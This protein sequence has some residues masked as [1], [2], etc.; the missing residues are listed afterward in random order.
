M[1]YYDIPY[2]EKEWLE[3]MKRQIKKTISNNLP[4][5]SIFGKY[6]SKM[7]LCSFKNCSFQDSAKLNSYDFQEN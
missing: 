3:L 2:I 4:Y 7:K 5:H 6:F 1:I